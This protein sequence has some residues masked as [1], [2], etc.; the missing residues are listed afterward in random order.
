MNSELKNCTIPI[1]WSEILQFLEN[2]LED[3]VLLRI[4]Y[5]FSSSISIYAIRVSIGHVSR[6]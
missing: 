6:L 3:I 1:F 4:S 2:Y 5:G